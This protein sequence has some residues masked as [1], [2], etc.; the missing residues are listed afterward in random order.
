MRTKESDEEMT[1]EQIGFEVS[2]SLKDEFKID[3][4]V[5]KKNMSEV[6]RT[7]LREYLDRDEEDGDEN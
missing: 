4:I 6:L 1:R 7:L 2:K 3:C 5:K